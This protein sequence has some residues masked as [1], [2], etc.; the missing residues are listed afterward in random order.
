VPSDTRIPDQCARWGE[1]LNR[2]TQPM[3]QVWIDAFWMD[4][5][6]VA[7]AAYR[8]CASTGACSVAPLVTGDTRHLGERLPIVNITRAEANRY[9]QW[10]GGRLPT[11]AEWEW[12]ARGSDDR[13]WPWGNLPRPDDFNHGK[14]RSAVLTSLDQVTRESGI[15]TSG[16]PDESDGWMYAAPPGSKRWSDSPSG[17]HDMA[18]NV[19]E[20]VLDD[21]DELGFSGLSKT[22]PLRVGLPGSAAMTRGGSWRDPAFAARVDVPS[23]QSAFTQLRPLEPETRAVNIGFRCVYG[24]ATPEVATAL[25]P[26]APILP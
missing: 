2:R 25:E 7:T 4:A 12:A 10:R 3:H 8:A 5:F 22:N 24:A 18:G 14:V 21:F 20:W 16:D 17:V 19:A 6:E 15:R 1:T 11:E 13:T 23:Y 9:C 26:R